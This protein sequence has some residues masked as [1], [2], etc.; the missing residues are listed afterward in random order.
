MFVLAQ[1]KEQLTTELFVSDVFYM[2]CTVFVVIA[3]AGLCFLDMGLV[4][5][6]N[7]VDTVTQKMV[8][9]FIC[10]AGWLI[11]GM[12]IWNTQVYQAF[13]IENPF[14]Q[15]IKDWWFGG[16]MVQK[17]PQFIDPAVAPQ[18]E[19]SQIYNFLF[20]TFALFLGAAIHTAGVERVKASTT[21]VIS[22]VWGLILLPFMVYLLWGSSSI[23]TNQGIH[24]MVGGIALYVPLGVTAL[25]IAKA[26]GPRLG[27][28]GPHPRAGTPEPANLALAAT[29]LVLILAALPFFV[30][31]GGYL[32]PGVGY[33]GISMTTTSIGHVFGA[34]YVSFIA[35]GLVGAVMSYRTRNP[36]WAIVAPFV[37]YVSCASIFDTATFWVIVI[38]AGIAPLVAYATYWL[39]HE[40]LKIDEGK[41]VPLALGPAIYGVIVGGFTE[42]N[43]KIG[44]YIG[45]TEG[46]YAFQ[47]AEV[48]PWWQAIAVGVA[49]VGTVLVVGTVV[50]ILKKTVGIRVTEEQEIVGLDEAYWGGADVRHATDEGHPAVAEEFAVEPRS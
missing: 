32:F 28:Y 6:K 2:V 5:A 46:K 15:S 49:I 12:A 17:L 4:R 3:V 44:G 26:A 31:G 21:Y 13:G 9:A 45:I 10:A 36:Y 27:M 25:I 16:A 24:D 47:H 8:A 29:G 1:F 20:V 19:I 7:F 39:F 33:F 42:W 22:F 43:E 14:G 38:V 30:T 48:T 18:V 40:R 41:L 23:L 34:V 35:A 37:G 11:A 50:L